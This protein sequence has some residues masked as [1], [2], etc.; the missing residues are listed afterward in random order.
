[1]TYLNHISERYITAGIDI[2]CCD[3]LGRTALD[4]AVDNENVEIADL[5]LQE[6]GIKIGHSLLYAIREGVYQVKTG[7]R[8]GFTIGGGIYE[9]QKW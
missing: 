8:Q 6:T 3:V 1:M 5:L 4:I 7:W 9:D 2:N